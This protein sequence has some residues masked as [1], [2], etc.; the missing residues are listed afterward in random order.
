VLCNAV[1]KAALTRV[2]H[3]GKRHWLSLFADH[4]L[5]TQANEKMKLV[6]AL[7]DGLAQ[8]IKTTP[9]IKIQEG[10]FSSCI[11]YRRTVALEHFVGTAAVG[12]TGAIWQLTHALPVSVVVL[13][14]A[15]ICCA[16][17]GHRQE[18]QQIISEQ[19]NACKVKLASVSSLLSLPARQLLSVG[20][21]RAFATVR[22]DHG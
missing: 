22:S 6:E 15:L 19:A 21:G 16:V 11:R 18:L 12:I 7:H 4:Q 5:V 9:G 3:L 10:G 2:G 13:Q 14:S 17:D 1:V 20:P 8:A